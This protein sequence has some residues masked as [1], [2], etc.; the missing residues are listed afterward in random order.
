VQSSASFIN[1]YGSFLEV[2]KKFYP[3]HNWNPLLF[4]KVPQG[5]W[6]K[7]ST[8]KHFHK[9]LKKWKR[10]HKIKELRDWYQL[11]PENVKLFQQVSQGIFGSVTK[12]LEEWFPSTNWSVA[13]QSS[14]PELDL[15]V[16]NEFHNKDREKH[17]L[18]SASFLSLSLFFF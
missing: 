10:E 7:E 9:L 18:K 5:Y 4:S 12:M 17:I 14:T 6:M 11:P 15:Q 2:L 8:K 3:E 16:K 1:Y 13:V